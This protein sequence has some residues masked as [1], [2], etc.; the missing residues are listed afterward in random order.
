M[1]TMVNTNLQLADPFCSLLTIENASFNT[2]HLWIFVDT[3]VDTFML[4]KVPEA[5]SGS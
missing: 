4:W 2:S 5:N 1:E 3:I